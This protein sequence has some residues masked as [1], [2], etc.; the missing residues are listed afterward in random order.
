MA[1]MILKCQT[2]NNFPE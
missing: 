1:F 2:I